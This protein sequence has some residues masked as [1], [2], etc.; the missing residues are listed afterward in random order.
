[1]Q[2]TKGIH[3]TLGAGLSVM[4][5]DAISDEAIHSDPLTADSR[6]KWEEGGE[7][8]S[9]SDWHSHGCRKGHLLPENC[10]P[11]M[12]FAAFASA[13]ASP[14]RKGLFWGASS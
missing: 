3:N 13:C 9:Q 5:R 11:E 8:E 6:G 1:M 14:S 2:S 4:T 7:L 10:N 12:S